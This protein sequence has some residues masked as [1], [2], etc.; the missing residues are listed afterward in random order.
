MAMVPDT[1]MPP[2][3]VVVSLVLHAGLAGLLAISKACK[4]DDSSLLMPDMDVMM[5]PL[6]KASGR[7]PDRASRAPR[8]AEGANTPTPPQQS[9]PDQMRFEDPTKEKPKGE[10]KPKDHSDARQDLLRNMKRQQALDALRD[11]PI[12]DADRMATDPDS[13]LTV[14]EVFGLGGGYGGPVDP[15]AARYLLE[16]RAALLPH[17]NP[18]PRIIE[19]HPDAFTVLD[20]W[21]TDSGRYKNA[22]VK[23][24]SGDDSFDRSCL[25]AAAKAGTLPVPPDK[26]RVETPKGIQIRVTFRASDAKH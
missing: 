26:F 24:G 3:A 7:L 8:P 2:W 21:I 11:A 17:W 10:D 15:E 19:Q 1:H 20:V 9:D 13:T 4:P 22:D 16:L 6:P 18:L 12:G 25:T 23:I 5:V 14:E